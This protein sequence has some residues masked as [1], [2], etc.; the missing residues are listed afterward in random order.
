MLKAWQAVDPQGAV[1]S[2]LLAASESAEAKP[3]LSVPAGPNVS[4][5]RFAAFAR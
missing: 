2:G 5:R 1:A 3:E 4:R